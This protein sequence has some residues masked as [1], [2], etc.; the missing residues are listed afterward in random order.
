LRKNTLKGQVF[1]LF[2]KASQYC[3]FALLRLN[4]N[5]QISTMKKLT[6]NQNQIIKIQV[7]IIMLFS[8]QFNIPAAASGI[9]TRHINSS[10]ICL[11]CINSIQATQ[12]EGSLIEITMLE[13]TVPLEATFSDVAEYSEVNLVPSTPGEASFDDVEEPNST[14]VPEYLGP[15]TIQEADFND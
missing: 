4:N 3:T 7:I 6:D 2:S 12:K 15:I 9:E 13:P 5:K 8:L 14:S 10:S 11:A 1:Q